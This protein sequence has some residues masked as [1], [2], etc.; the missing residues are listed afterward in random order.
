MMRETIAI[1]AA[2]NEFPR[3]HRQYNPPETV[4]RVA[5]IKVKAHVD[6]PD[7]ICDRK[8]N[9]EYSR[10]SLLGEAEHDD[11]QFE[12]N[13]VQGGF[14]QCYQV[15]DSTGAAFA[16]KVIPKTS[17][18]TPKQKHKLFAEIKIHQML[19]HPNIVKFHHV[20]EDDHNVYMILE[21]CHNK[22]FVDFLKRRRR[23]TEPEVRYFMLQLLSGVQYMH[24]ERI[25]HR[26]LKL[27][28][29]FI[30][31]DMQLKIG[32]FG[33]A[34]ILKHD[35][36]RKK[37]ICGTPNYIAPEVLFDTNN[38]HSFEVDIWSLGVV[39]YTM[40]IGKPPF[41][42]KD[43][44]A[45]YKKIR[46]NSYE[47]PLSV[48][49]SDLG[50]S[51]IASLLHSKPESRPVID[52]VLRHPFFS[53]AIPAS[54]PIS[55][56]HEIPHFPTLIRIPQPTTPTASSLL[57][58]LATLSVSPQHPPR[59]ARTVLAELGL[60]AATQTPSIS[61]LNENVLSNGTTPNG[62]PSSLLHVQMPG[63]YVTSTL[64]LHDTRSNGAGALRSKYSP[65]RMSPAPKIPQVPSP[66]T[67]PPI[68]KASLPANAISS[69]P[70]SPAIKAFRMSTYQTATTNMNGSSPAPVLS[71][72]V[73][74]PLIH[75]TEDVKSSTPLLFRQSVIGSVTN[76]YVN[77]L[78]SMQDNLTRALDDI[79][80]GVISRHAPIPDEIL[81]TPKVFISKWIDYSNKYGLGYQLTNGCVGVYFNDSTSIILAPDQQHFEYLYCDRES[82][83]SSI[84]RQAYTMST[85]SAELN[86]KV[87]LLLHFRSYMQE[88]LFQACSLQCADT[89]AT[90]NLEFLTKYMRTKH[91]VVF[92]LSNRVV[93]INFFDHSKI[94]L[95][96]DAQTITYIDK[97]RTMQTLSL[98]TLT[99][100]YGDAAS[101][102]EVIDRLHYAK[103]IIAQMI[104]K[105]QS[106]QRAS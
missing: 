104:V 102:Q 45:I 69:P 90:Q 54:I 79:K 91:G 66:Q 28:N 15:T 82:I 63:A 103:D 4:A 95:S 85:Y 40:L 80:A 58:G 24:R 93:Q 5:D 23:M 68:I 100:R 34:A 105:K 75:R 18:R 31:S 14:A 72:S 48:E 43:V 94:V 47:F 98:N 101:K 87:T 106:R 12:S 86:K 55:A 50:R 74:S 61:P 70:F 37:T 76:R 81:Q 77:V 62:S 1:P 17:L 8:Q 25:I 89:T 2:L 6:I 49:V 39:M 38:G 52:D 92:R 29:L 78:E 53:E 44:K 56:L 26:D 16:A 41:Q 10:G 36:E 13:N 73:S 51:L 83:R 97:A 19:S 64:R 33:L 3:R 35:G 84:H 20:F 11:D 27:G 32:D 88:N 22:T 60:Q 7:V 42:T 71:R 99:K 46:E 67:S 21:L 59:P 65:A 9:K 30:S 57:N 96:N